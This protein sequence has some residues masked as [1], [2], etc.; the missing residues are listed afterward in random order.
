M[1][2]LQHIYVTAHGEFTET[3]WVG[4]RAQIGVR[5]AIATEGSEPP[6]GSMFT[7]DPSNGDV[8]MDSSTH[9]GAHGTLTRTWTARLGPVGSAEN[10]DHLFQT[11][12]AEDFW[13]YLT[14]VSA[15]LYTGFRWTHVKIAP[16]L[17]DGAYGAPSA[18]YTF[19]SPIAGGATGQSLL[20]PEVALAVSFRAAVLGRRGRGRFYLPALTT[21]W[22]TNAGLVQTTPR[23]TVR[24]ATATLV[25]NL[26]NAPGNEEYGPILVTMSAGS[27]TATRPSEVRIGNHF[28]AQRRRQHQVAETYAVTPL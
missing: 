4:E 3:N 6:K 20:P 27:S 9:A 11:D 5:L 17:A 19:S 10:A 16:V 23:D 8:V 22:I 28:D 25:T 1:A 7:L 14:A 13:T 21:G 15:T 24:S 12:L 2:Q 18:T 26:E